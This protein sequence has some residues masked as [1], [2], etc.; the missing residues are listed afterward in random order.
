MRGGF[1]APRCHHHEIERAGEAPATRL[2]MPAGT[3]SGSAAGDDP[4]AGLFSP[5]E[6]ANYLADAGYGSV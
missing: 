6:C 1:V 3:E 2:L 5:A 4:E